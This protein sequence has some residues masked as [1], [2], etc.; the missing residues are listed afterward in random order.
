MISLFSFLSSLWI[1]SRVNASPPANGGAHTCLG[2]HHLHAQIVGGRT[3]TRMGQ[4]GRPRPTGLGPF[5]P[6]LVA[7][8]STWVLLPFCTW[9]PLIASFWR[10]HPRVQDRGLLTWSP[11]FTL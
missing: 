4:V 8:S 5:Q 10:R 6:S 11:F 9:T 3:D 1:A 7:P 2:L